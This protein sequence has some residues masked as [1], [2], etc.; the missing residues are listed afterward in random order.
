M[1]VL[2]LAN[3]LFSFA[4]LVFII[5]SIAGAASESSW[6]TGKRWLWGILSFVLGLLGSGMAFWLRGRKTLAAVSFVLLIVSIII[7]IL[8]FKNAGGAFR[9]L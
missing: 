5:I 3:I 6:S 2:I 4:S 9:Q 8:L 1:T 7:N